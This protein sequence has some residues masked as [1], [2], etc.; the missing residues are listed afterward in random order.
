M[1][2]ESQP[3]PYLMLNSDGEVIN[4]IVWD[5][6]TETWQPPEGVKMVA[7]DAPEAAKIEAA[8]SKRIAAL[9]AVAAS[10]KP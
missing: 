9:E 5:G 7:H 4:R 2:K 8:E 10:G 6:N 1:G 3:Q